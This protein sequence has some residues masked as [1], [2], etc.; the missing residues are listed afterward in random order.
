MAEAGDTSA[1]IFRVSSPPCRWGSRG[2]GGGGGAVGRLGSVGLG[3]PL[4]MPHLEVGYKP[5]D[6][7]FQPCWSGLICSTVHTLGKCSQ[8]I[9]V[10]QMG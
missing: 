6:P 2:G 9:D 3:S 10:F 7:N 5:F 4:N 1:Q 8:L